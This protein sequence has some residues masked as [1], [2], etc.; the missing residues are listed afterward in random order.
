MRALLTAA[1]AVLALAAGLLNSS[2]ALAGVANAGVADAAASDPL[3]GIPWGNYTGRNDEVF[4]AYRQASGEDKRLLG[5]IAL[6]PRVR[7]FG[8]WYPDS[9]AESTARDYIANAT[10]GNPNALAQLAVFRLVPWEGAAC[11]AIASTAQVS[12]YK[13]WID[14]FAAG[15]GSSRVALI[16]Q[17]DL[18]FEECVPHHSQLP[19][20]LVAYAARQFSALPHTS[21]YIDAGAG[22]WPTVR[23]ATSMLLGAGIRY[24]RGFALNDTHYDSTEHEIHFG[25]KVVGAL[26]G[27]GVPGRHFVINTSSNG[28]GFTF[29][30]YHGSNFDNAAVCRS[31]ASRRCATLG[32]PPTTDV[33]NPRWGL[34]PGARTQARRFVDAYLWIGRP[35]LDN[36]ADPF[37]LQ[38]SLA[39][40]RTTP[41]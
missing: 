18:P 28:R 12:S 20:Q 3:A 21:V 1:F 33:A 10:H 11:H 36:Q 23:A 34:S 39:L 14:A 9:R 38:R 37:D 26:A 19:L 2:T 4:P 6:R 7:W 30:Q 27:H 40:A 17:P 35:W 13:Q 24:A 29:Q 15:I 16:L 31:R 41:F 32:I 25:A 22:D 5:L 8:S